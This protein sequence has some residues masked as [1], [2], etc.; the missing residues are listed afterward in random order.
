M[1]SK[2][3]ELLESNGLKVVVKVKKRNTPCHY[4]RRQIS[5]DEGD[6]L[7]RKHAPNWEEHLHND[8]DV[9]ARVISRIRWG[10]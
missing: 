4:K 3:R 7:L 2:I 10:K 5:E 9:L 6:E 1:R 8:I